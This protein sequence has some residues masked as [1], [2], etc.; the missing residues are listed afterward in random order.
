MARFKLF[1]RYRRPSLSTALGVTRAKR[2][3]KSRSGYYA[4][5]RWTRTRA[6]QL[7]AARPAPRGL[8]LRPNEVLPLHAP[9]SALGSP[10]EAPLRPVDRVLALWPVAW[11]P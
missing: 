11:A 1:P 7:P 6:P 10:S 5:T 9:Q 3:L 4:A 8:L 2:R